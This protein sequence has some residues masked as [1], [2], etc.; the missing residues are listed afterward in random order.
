MLIRKQGSG[1]GGGAGG[2]TFSDLVLHSRGSVISYTVPSS[3]IILHRSAYRSKPALPN[4]TQMLSMERVSPSTLKSMRSKHS[5]SRRGSTTPG[6]FIASTALSSRD[7]GRPSLVSSSR[8]VC[9]VTTS[10]GAWSGNRPGLLQ[11]FVSA[12]LASVAAKSSRNASAAR[13]AVRVRIAAPS[14]LLLTQ[15][16]IGQRASTPL[17][18]LPSLQLA[19]SHLASLNAKRG[20]SQ[21]RWR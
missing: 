10:V 20:D 16:L 5:P 7:A 6:I 17:H 3:A 1:G 18:F 14:F 21:Q 11:K 19:E 9:S 12:A 15:R 2:V 4:L 8:S 13:T